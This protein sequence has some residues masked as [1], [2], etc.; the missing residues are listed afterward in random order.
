M[1]ILIYCTYATAFQIV[2]TTTK[3]TPPNFPRENTGYA[4]V[5]K[6]IGE[7]THCFQQSENWGLIATSTASHITIRLVYQPRKHYS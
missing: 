2:C 1:Y 7:S 6:R 5:L 4:Y 3:C